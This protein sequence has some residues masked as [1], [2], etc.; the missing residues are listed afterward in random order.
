MTESY[1]NH[2]RIRLLIHNTS[3][4][5]RYDDMYRHK[6]NG[7]A[8]IFFIGDKEWFI[9]SFMHRNDGPAIIIAHGLKQWWMNGL[10]IKTIQYD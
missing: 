4:L 2:L 9:D 3:I 6:L 7:P 8:F 5:Y 1:K 10:K